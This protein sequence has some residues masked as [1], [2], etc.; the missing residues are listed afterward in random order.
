M[1]HDPI[2]FDSPLGPVSLR[3]E[4]DADRDFRYWLFCNSRQPE[5]ALLLPPPVFEQVMRHQFQAQ[6]VSYLADFPRARFDIIELGRRPI[7]RIVVDR[8]GDV[9]YIVDQAIVPELRN[10][11]IGTAIMRGLMGEARAAGVPVRLMASQGDP[12]MR[13]Y[14][15]LGFAVTDAATPMYTTLE[16]RPAAAEG[17][18]SC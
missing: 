18:T 13:L 9:V 8:P 16:W 4:T 17:A 12:A 5:F 15:R 14:A 2:E 3:T 10:K 11:G 6:T 1:S 7:G